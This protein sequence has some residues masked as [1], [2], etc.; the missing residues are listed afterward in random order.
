M[1]GGDLDR[2][3]QLSSRS[4]EGENANNPTYLDTYAWILFL[5]G[6][7]EKAREVQAKAVEIMGD[8]GGDTE[9]YEH[10]GDILD[11]TGDKAAAIEA[12]KKALDIDDSRNDIR[13]KIKNAEKETQQ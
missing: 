11:K 12:W 13:E 9:V 7:Y 4:L 5:K 6:D 1:H 8:H 10:Y 3:L 2:A